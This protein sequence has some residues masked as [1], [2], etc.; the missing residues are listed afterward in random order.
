MGVTGI[1]DGTGGDPRV[2]RLMPRYAYCIVLCLVVYIL[3][4]NKI[5]IRAF[6]EIIDEGSKRRKIEKLKKEAK[7]IKKQDR[8]L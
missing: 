1:P 2:I 4:R 6:F 8:K 7:F 5:Y 3:Y